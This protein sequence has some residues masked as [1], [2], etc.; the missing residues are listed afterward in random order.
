VGIEGIFFLDYIFTTKGES[1][2][3][4]T[5]L[6]IYF[7]ATY[8]Q[9]SSLSRKSHEG[10]VD[11]VNNAQSS[12]KAELHEPFVG[13]THKHLVNL[14]GGVKYVPITYICINIYIL[15]ALGT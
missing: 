8:L 6:C 1:A 12:W 13:L 4:P 14:A 9:S 2:P 10:I 5:I 3:Q 11:H 15:V 7:M